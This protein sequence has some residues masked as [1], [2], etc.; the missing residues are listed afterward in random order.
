MVKTR[1]N[2]KH[3]FN[4]KMIPKSLYRILPKNKIRAQITDKEGGILK[5]FIDKKLNEEKI[6][7]LFSKKF[8]FSRGWL[9]RFIIFGRYRIE[10]LK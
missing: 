8:K 1:K 4:K 7:K 3:D 9:N 2:N 5:Y 10:E 6:I